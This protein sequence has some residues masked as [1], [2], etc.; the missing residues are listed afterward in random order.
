MMARTQKPRKWNDAGIEG[1]LLDD[2]ED[3]IQT[4]LGDPQYL[5]SLVVLGLAALLR[6]S[7][8][9]PTSILSDTRV[10][11]ICKIKRLERK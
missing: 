6:A 8:K 4:R 10:V 1:R 3:E 11:L 2:L 5:G 7:L 9:I